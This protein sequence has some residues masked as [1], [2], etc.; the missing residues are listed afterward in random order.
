MSLS[1]VTKVL[2]AVNQAVTIW[3][4]GQAKVGIGISAV[5]GAP[6]LSFSGST[7]GLTFNPITVGPYPSAVPSAAGVTTAG[8]AGNW[9]VDVQNY[10]FIRVQMTAATGASPSAA[11]IVAA[12]NDGSYQ[13]AFDAPGQYGTNLAVLYP[14]TTS[15][16]GVN[17]MTIPAQANR[18]INLTWLMY[19]SPGPGWGGNATLRIWDGF[20]GNGAPLFQESITPPAGSVGNEVVVS[21]PRDAQ[22]NQGI[23][24]SPG[25]ALVV[26]VVNLGSNFLQLNARSSMM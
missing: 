4:E 18:S 25:N 2:T 26:Q 16:G 12:S 15:S 24:G 1:K 23:Q 9:E 6:T 3:C 21:L 14:S 22:G 10:K 11:V 20:V 17:T 8:A 19:S 13:E 5:T 7:D